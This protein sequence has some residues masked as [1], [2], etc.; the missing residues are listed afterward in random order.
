MPYVITTRRYDDPYAHDP[1]LLDLSRVAV[2]TLAEARETVG[3]ILDEQDQSRWPAEL[4]P[5]APVPESGGTVGP[6]PDGTIIEVTHVKWDELREDLR[7]RSIPL[8]YDYGHAAEAICAAFN[9]S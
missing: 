6:L 8:T 2:A 9:A 5:Y 3:L 7:S 4:N 1:A